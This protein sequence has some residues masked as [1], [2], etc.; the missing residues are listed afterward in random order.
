MTDIMFRSLKRD[1]IKCL[2]LHS[3]W[4]CSQP[5][6]VRWN[7]SRL[8]GM[9]KCCQW[10]T[11]GSSRDVGVTR[12]RCL[13]CICKRSDLDCG[14]VTTRKIFTC[15]SLDLSSALMLFLRLSLC[16]HALRGFRVCG[17]GCATSP[18]CRNA[19]T[20]KS[21]TSSVDNRHYFWARNCSSV[22]IYT[23]CTLTF[24]GRHYNKKVR[25]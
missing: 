16:R 4:V 11:A 17:K 18:C 5:L 23:D 19:T 21:S 1:C 2:G 3:T 9:L 13:H 24:L 7:L 14:T 8:V 20:G 15:V 12:K 22:N 25:I 10:C 6:Q